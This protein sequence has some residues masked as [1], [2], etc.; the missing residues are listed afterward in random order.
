MRLLRRKRLYLVLFVMIL[1]MLFFSATWMRMWIYPI[2]YKEIIRQHAAKYKVD[3]LLIAAIIRQESNYRPSQESH[4]GA[5]GMM[6]IMPDTAVWI[7]EKASMKEITLDE[8]KH[9]VDANIQIG[10]WY[11]SYLLTKFDNNL[12]AVLAA[13]NAGPGVVNKWLQ[14]RTWDGTFDQVKKIPYPETKNY[15]QRVVYYYN[16][17][18]ELYTEL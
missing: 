9:E 17:Y 3:P 6:Q 11:I 13:Y 14:N 12:F 16:K 4:K 8:V 7:M 10:A 1:T 15:V 5:L 2:Q 18:K